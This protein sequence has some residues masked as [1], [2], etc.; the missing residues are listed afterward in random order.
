[1]IFGD[2]R[3]CGKLVQSKKSNCATLS[4]PWPGCRQSG[5]G[6]VVTGDGELPMAM[7][8]TNKPRD[9]VTATGASRPSRQNV[10][11]RGGQGAEMIDGLELG[12]GG[13]EK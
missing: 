1:V 5:V 8:T 9:H 2:K 3:S 13:M 7:R 6:A 11:K 10:T 12:G 4:P